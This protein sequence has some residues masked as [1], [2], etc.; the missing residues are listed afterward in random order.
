MSNR[1]ITSIEHRP[2]DARIVY[3][4]GDEV[5]P[6]QFGITFRG[7]YQNSFRDGLVESQVLLMAIGDKQMEDLER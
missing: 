3:W 7:D 5:E 6:Q 1:Y 4:I 2:Q